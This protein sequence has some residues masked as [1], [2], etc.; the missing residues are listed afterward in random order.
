MKKENQ[1][2]GI[3]IGS[4]I[5]ERKLSTLNIKL[6]TFNFPISIFNLAFLLI[7]LTS[8]HIYSFKDVSIPPEVKTVKI[9]LFEN[10]A[11]Y[12]D[13]QLAPQLRDRV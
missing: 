5:L 11:R 8:C 10:K 12:V 7:L 1:R 9:G 4:R 3:E 2:S 6:K 13:P